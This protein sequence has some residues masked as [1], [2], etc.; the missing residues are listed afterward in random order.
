MPSDWDYN[1]VFYV[2]K[3]NLKK[4]AR[5]HGNTEIH[6]SPIQFNLLV[7][8]H[9]VISLRNIVFSASLVRY[10]YPLKGKEQ[11]PLNHGKLVG[12]N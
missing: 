3:L 1:I 6:P 4:V 11:Q 5:L 10:F 8:L 2:A 12:R 9:R 7:A